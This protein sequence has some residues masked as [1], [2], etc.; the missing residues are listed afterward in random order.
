MS[1]LSDKKNDQ[2]EE[3][4]RNGYQQLR[5][6]EQNF[7]QILNKGTDD[8]LV[9][10][11]YK[12]TVWRSLLYYVLCVVTLGGFWL[13]LYWRPDWKIKLTKTPCLLA[14]ADEVLLKDHFN[15]QLT[16]EVQILLLEEGLGDF[17]DRSISLVKSENLSDE[18][19]KILTPKQRPH[20][21]FFVHQYL[22]Y[23]WSHE[24]RA[25]KLLV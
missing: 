11:G 10:Y 23:F 21:R 15:Q 25:F 18:D 20:T 17:R 7:S 24:E 9:C 2:E 16:A 12:K 1:L 22:R 6:P 13:V 14:Y 8:Q 3:G 4:S 5:P 19:T